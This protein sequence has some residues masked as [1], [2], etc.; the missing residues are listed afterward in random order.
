VH[1]YQ[2]EAIII[3]K[4]KLGEADRILT[5][6]TP[7]LG[8]IQAV[9]K[10]VR[11]PKSKMAGHLELLTHSQLSLSRGRSLDIISACQTIN[12]YLPLK[13]DLDLTACGLYITELAEQ[14]TIEEQENRLLFDLLRDTLQ[15][16]CETGNR[17]MVLH[18][19]EMQVLEQAGYR[20][21]LYRC[22]CCEKPLAPVTNYFSFSEGGVICPD[23]RSSYPYARPLSVN[24]L[25]VLRLLQSNDVVT[26][27][28]LKITSAL[29]E[30]MEGIIRRYIKYLLEKDLKSTA[31]MDNLKSSP[32]APKPD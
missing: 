17:D 12:S 2:T 8:K 13:N 27:L 14:F 11:K 29:A 30:E 1:T 5:M 18:H 26:A 10:G 19:Y 24:A 21:E 25:K 7:E 9:A 15:R 16:L 20:P 31:W 23:C 32:P 6:L 22:V 4:T 28:K 3:K